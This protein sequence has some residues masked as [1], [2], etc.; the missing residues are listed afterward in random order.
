MT[1]GRRHSTVFDALRATRDR[2]AEAS[3]PLHP[4]AGTK[5]G[6]S[7]GTAPPEYTGEAVFV[8]MRV[9]QDA[10]IA[11]TQVSPGG[12]TETY[13]LAIE[14][15][16]YVPGRTEDDVLDRLQVLSDTAQGQFYDPDTLTFRPPQFDGVMML[17]G[18][19]RV[20]PD[21]WQS[22]EGRQGDCLI[23]LTVVARI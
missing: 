23:G 20:V 9:E 21:L 1:A 18:V 2:L 22:D 13:E 7:F 15:G 6:L 5:V 17:G 8:R 19:G 11:W 10:S 12:R 14:I 4:T 16:S 3:W